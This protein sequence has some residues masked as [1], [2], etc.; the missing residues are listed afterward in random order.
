MVTSATPHRVTAGSASP[1]WPAASGRIAFTLSTRSSYSTAWSSFTTF[2]AQ[3]SISLTTYNL[4]HL[5]AFMT[6]LRLTLNLAPSSIRNYLL[7]IQHQ[8]LLRSPPFN[9]GGPPESLASSSPSRQPISS[10]S[11]VSQPSACGT[12]TSLKSPEI[13]FSYSSGLQNRQLHQDQEVPQPGPRSRPQPSPR[14]T[15]QHDNIQLNNSLSCLLQ[16]AHG[17]MENTLIPSTHSSYSTAWSSF[18][19]FC[20]LKKKRISHT[21]FN[22]QHLLAFITHPGPSLRLAPSSI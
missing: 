13:T 10:E 22:L 7:G 20:E 11:P 19:H 2:C 6:D 21:S 18:T 16:S 8:F 4:Q 3:I 9:P 12:M 5:L 14:T 1:S 17:F 15:L